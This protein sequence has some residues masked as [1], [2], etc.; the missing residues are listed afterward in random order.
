MMSRNPE[1]KTYL[2]L[3]ELPVNNITS[4]QIGAIIKEKC[5]G[6]VPQDPV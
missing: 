3:Y 2:Y 4:V 6:Y 1:Y 5:G